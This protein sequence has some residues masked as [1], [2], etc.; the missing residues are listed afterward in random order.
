MGDKPV[1]FANDICTSRRHCQT[2]R[3]R[4]A[5]R[6]WRNAL[7]RIFRLP[8]NDFDC[9]EGKPWIEDRETTDGRTQ[10]KP[11]SCRECRAW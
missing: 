4:H 2:C 11:S 6:P 7:R 1:F 10:S 5:G 8:G 9:P 3:A